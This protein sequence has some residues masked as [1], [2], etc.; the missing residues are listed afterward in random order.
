MLIGHSAAYAAGKLIPGLLGMAAT[1]LLTR[2]LDPA[3]YGR[4]GLA[5]VVTGL[6]STLMFDWLG[7]AY[8][9]LSA[10]TRAVESTVTA[11][12]GL[13]ATLVALTAGGVWLLGGFSGEAGPAIAA[14]LL[15]T[16]CASAFE[17]AA[18][19]PVA[20]A[21]PGRF[22]VMN[23]GRGVLTLAGAAGAAWLTRDA[24]LTICGTAFGSI[25]GV[26]LAG[27]TPAWPK[28]ERASAHRLLRF[29]L[30]L[31]G[32]LG[33]ASVANSGVR[34]LLDVLGS[35]SALGVY[36]AAYLI[37]QN[38]LSVAAAGI[39]SAGYPA[40]VRALERGDREG[41]RRQMG[42]NWSLLLAVLSPMALGMA[43]TA[44]TLAATLA[45]PRFAPDIA[46]LTPWL[47]AAGWFAALRA[48]GLD[49]VFH[50]AN[51]PGRLAAVT[52]AS[53]LLALVVAFALIPS[54]GTLGAA[55]ASL[56]AAG[57]S[58]ALALAWGRDSFLVAL[59]VDTVVRVA[60]AC[61]AMSA[62]VATAPDAFVPEVAAGVAGYAA[63][64]IVF[65]VLGVRR[66]AWAAALRPNAT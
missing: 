63:G 45:G 22:L 19:H 18:R 14:G 8:L 11:M 15:L 5:L 59:P 40:A 12:F 20:E 48:H 53:A 61:A 26:L 57:G 24:A 41:A 29:G 65:D 58:C 46:A 6:G 50:L 55:I 54:L 36:T 47:A 64:C 13:M 66:A 38:T 49:H 2:L 44:P 35:A 4:Y 3:E 32:G 52:G 39:A 56:V 62:A 17:L 23:C 37:V 9:R 43:L 30:P 7:L 60:C 34:G 10:G 28:L 42:A 33:L 27:Q 16:C 51:R 25:G 1:A 21:R 31:A